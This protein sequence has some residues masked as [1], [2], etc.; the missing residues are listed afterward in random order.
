MCV[1]VYIRACMCVFLSCRVPDVK[2]GFEKWGWGL[3]TEKLLE[4]REDG[5][6]A[7]ECWRC[8]NIKKKRRKKEE[9]YIDIEQRT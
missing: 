5:E 3:G 6:W 9:R 8:E 1:S 4:G 7:E 2:K